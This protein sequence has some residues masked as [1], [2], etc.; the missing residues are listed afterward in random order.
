MD[1]PVEKEVSDK[2]R[3]VREAEAVIEDIIHHVHSVE[4]STEL[5]N[6]NRTIYLNLKTLEKKEYCIEMSYSGFQVVGEKFDDRSLSP[7]E[8]C[9]T[10]Y[11]LLSSLSVNY[12]KSFAGELM[13]KLN[14]LNNANK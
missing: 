8:Y 1:E 9:E 5:P 7:D 4:I 6:T 3:W 10:P 2:E 14:K 11:S 12:D 13:E